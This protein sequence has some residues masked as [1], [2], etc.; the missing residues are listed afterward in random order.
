MGK[1]IKMAELRVSWYCSILTVNFAAA[2]VK[3]PR[4]QAMRGSLIVK[5]RVLGQIA[6]CHAFFALD[7]TSVRLVCICIC[8]DNTD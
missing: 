8:A 1:S 5:L 4:T 6:N 7:G 3:Q 2:V